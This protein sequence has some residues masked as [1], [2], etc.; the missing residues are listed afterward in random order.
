MLV[1]IEKIKKSTNLLVISELN[2]FLGEITNDSFI[3]CWDSD[4]E[5]IEE[6]EYMFYTI[7]KN[8][9]FQSFCAKNK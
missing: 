1:R 4:V 3:E 5:L 9:L 2:K 8:I 7:D 6:D